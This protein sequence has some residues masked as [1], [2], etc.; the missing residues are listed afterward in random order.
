MNKLNFAEAEK[1]EVT[2]R[3]KANI[4]TYPAWGKVEEMESKGEDLQTSDI[5]KFL[6]DCGLSMESFALLTFQQ[7]QDIY[8]ELLGLKKN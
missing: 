3:G 5:K 6:E 2:V 7:V 8:T 1:L 4:L